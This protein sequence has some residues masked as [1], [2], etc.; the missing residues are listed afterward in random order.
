M[1]EKKKTTTIK[2]N[3]IQLAQNMEKALLTR[4]PAA[5]TSFRQI[6]WRDNKSL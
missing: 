4:A 1:I 6:L 2:S 5:V 3:Y